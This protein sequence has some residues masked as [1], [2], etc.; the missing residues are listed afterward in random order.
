[1]S[2]RNVFRQSA[3][4]RLSSPEQLDT[5]TRVTTPKGWIALVAVGLLIAI[6]AVWSIAGSQSVKIT[7]D[8]FIVRPGGVV[9][10]G[11]TVE[12][13][14]TDVRIRL[15]DQVKRGDVIARV[16]QPELMDE[17]L[18]LRNLHQATAASDTKAI[19]E[20]DEAILLQ[21][22]LI[23]ERTRIVSPYDGRVLEVGA[24]KYDRLSAGV[25][26]ATLELDGGTQGGLQTIMYIPAQ[27]GKKITPGMEVSINPTSINKEEYGNLL[28]RVVS[29][30]EYPAT[31]QS[32]MNTLGNEAFVR[33]LSVTGEAL[34]EVRIEM[35][36]D[37]STPSGY[38]WSTKEGPPMKLDSGTPMTG[39]ITL[40]KQKPITNVLPFIR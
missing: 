34:L 13:Q 7:G 25:P 22:Q 18:R 10:I 38:R 29:I 2:T 12:G 21:E 9:A 16:S 11:A 20:L 6:A 24:K 37:G 28:G 8:G 40:Y 39:S 31:Q 32:M 1:M 23:S 36:T 15:N 30:S 14:I 26:V 4:D 27:V 5:L 3:V 17:L 33:Q 19:A 35:L